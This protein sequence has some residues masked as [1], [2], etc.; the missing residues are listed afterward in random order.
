M[1]EQ[2]VSSIS[3]IF[4]G[5]FICLFALFI[6]KTSTVNIHLREKA[7]REKIGG[8]LMAFVAL[9][10]CAKHGQSIFPGE[11]IANYFIPLALIFT[12]LSYFLLDYL[13]ARSF[14]ALLILF[15]H[16]HL[17]WIFT[18]NPPFAHLHHYHALLQEQPESSSPANL[19]C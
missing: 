10:W 11:K 12:W 15:A 19:A 5:I 9:I 7:C 4:Y 6:Q 2:I 17:H 8:V 1:T 13:A 14:A 18:L 3:M 16:Y